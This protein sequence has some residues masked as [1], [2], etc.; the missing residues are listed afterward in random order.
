MVDNGHAKLIGILA[1]RSTRMAL[2]G[3]NGSYHKAYFAQWYSVVVRLL[4]LLIGVRHCLFSL[5]AAVQR[6][7]NFCLITRWDTVAN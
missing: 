5:Q 4:L 1:E 3:R 7:L 2:I 6:S